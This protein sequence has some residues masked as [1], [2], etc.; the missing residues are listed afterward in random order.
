MLISQGQPG[1]LPSSSYLRPLFPVS[2]WT[3]GLFLP[4]V[5]MLKLNGDSPLKVVL[6][7]VGL[8][9]LMF[10]GK[11]LFEWSGAAEKIQSLF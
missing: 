9:L 10:V 11:R 8:A 2:S 4:Q 5:L 6:I 3:Y 7:I 1:S